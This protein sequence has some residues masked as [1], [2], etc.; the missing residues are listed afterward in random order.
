MSS[1]TSDVVAEKRPDTDF[2]LLTDGVTW[3]DRVSDLRKLVE[4]QNRG[5][6]TRIY[7]RA[8]GAQLQANLSDLKRDHA[9]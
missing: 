2:L 4:M 9:L 3:R 7:T 6:I 8:M 5:E 1:E